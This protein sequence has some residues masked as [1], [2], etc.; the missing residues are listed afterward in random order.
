MPEAVE[1]V[2]NAVL[3]QRSTRGRDCRIRLG[4]THGEVSRLPP[5]PRCFVNFLID[6]KRRQRARKR[7]SPWVLQG[8]GFDRDLRRLPEEVEV[9]LCSIGKPTNTA[10][11]LEGL[12][13]S[14]LLNCPSSLAGRMTSS[15]CAFFM[16]SVKLQTAI[17]DFH[18]RYQRRLNFNVLMVVAGP[19]TEISSTHYT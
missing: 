14:L 12:G 7:S 5:A 17:D 18:T 11:L 13:A 16:M 4:P 15:T 8:Q 9:V 1:H 3:R 19:L 6:L 10:C 2:D